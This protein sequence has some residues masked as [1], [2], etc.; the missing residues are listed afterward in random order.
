MHTVMPT[1]P[2]QA[3][4]TRILN[5]PPAWQKICLFTRFSTLQA[6]NSKNKQLLSWPSFFWSKWSLYSFSNFRVK[7]AFPGHFNE[8]FEENSLVEKLCTT[9]PKRKRNRIVYKKTDRGGSKGGTRGTGPP[10]KI[11]HL[12]FS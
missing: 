8:T 9:D 6:G 7:K 3:G 1:H 11:S 10:P 2:Y 5:S 12:K 4:V